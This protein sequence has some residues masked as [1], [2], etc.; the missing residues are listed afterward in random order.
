M[1]S[2]LTERYDDG[3]WLRWPSGEPPARDV[4]YLAVGCRIHREVSRL[5][6]PTAG[7]GARGTREIVAIK[8]VVKGAGTLRWQTRAGIAGDAPIRPEARLR[9]CRLGR[10]AERARAI[11]GTGASAVETVAREEA[12]KAEAKAKAKGHGKSAQPH[13]EPEP[14]SMS[15]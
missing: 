9:V 15:E 11:S 3:I 14:P 4:L 7:G 12:P 13:E 6:L 5:S 2:T 8:D 1:R 10:A